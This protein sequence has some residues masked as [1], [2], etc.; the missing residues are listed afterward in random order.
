[1]YLPLHESSQCFHGQVLLGLAMSTWPTR[2]LYDLAYNG[3]AASVKIEKMDG[4]IEMNSIEGSK[5]TLSNASA[6]FPR[7][8]FTYYLFKPYSRVVV[9]LLY[10]MRLVPTFCR[11][12]A[13]GANAQPKAPVGEVSSPPN[14]VPTSTF[15]T[16]QLL[17][18]SAPIDN[19]TRRTRT[20]KSKN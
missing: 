14:N 9:H 10:P 7:H 16:A 11:A 3:N 2:R 5:Y 8:Q 4:Q 6:N 18:V 20:T 15:V 17:S 19:A 12:L 1:M 13:T